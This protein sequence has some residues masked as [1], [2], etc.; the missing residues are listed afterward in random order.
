MIG[1]FAKAF[2]QALSKSIKDATINGGTI[3]G[4]GSPPG[5]PVAGA[6]LTIPPGGLV[7]TPPKI[8]PVF[9][10]PDFSS[11]DSNNVDQHG[12]YAAWLRA[13]VEHL[14]DSIAT[15]WNIWIKTWTLPSGVALGGVAAWIPPSSAAPGPWTGGTITPFIFM[16]QGSNSSPALDQ[17]AQVTV[18]TGKAKTAYVVSGSEVVGN[19][20]VADGNSKQLIE[21]VATGFSKTLEQFFE[22]VM[23]KDPTGSSATGTAFPPAGIVTGSITGLKFDVT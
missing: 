2:C 6:V 4:G 14:D 15:Q 3:S 9:D 18:R 19:V 22:Q 23:I 17:L 16:G 5:G 8:K 11:P 21:S 12:S 10:C 13:V 1:A 20:S 7:A